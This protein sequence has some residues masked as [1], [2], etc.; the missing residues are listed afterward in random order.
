MKLYL[1][2]LCS[3]IVN[4]LQSIPAHPTRIFSSVGAT[5]FAIRFSV[6]VDHNQVTIYC[7]ALELCFQNAQLLNFCIMKRPMPPLQ[8]H[9]DI[10]LHQKNS[11]PKIRFTFTTP[12]IYKM[13][14]YK[15]SH[16]ILSQRLKKLFKFCPFGNFISCI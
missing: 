1:R 12:L 3:I 10:Y 13:N 4:V 7:Q 6:L 9:R 14:I 2:V 11:T 16:A 15:S 5:M 8:I